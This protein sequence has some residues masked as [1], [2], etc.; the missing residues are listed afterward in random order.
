MVNYKKYSDRAMLAKPLDKMD[1]LERQYFDMHV[2]QKANEF[3][4]KYGDQPQFLNAVAI[5]VAKHVLN[6]TDNKMDE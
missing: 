5:E 1:E 3:I 6:K 4:G 2:S